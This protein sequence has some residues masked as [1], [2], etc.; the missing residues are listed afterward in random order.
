MENLVKRV[1]YRSYVIRDDLLGIKACFILL[2]PQVIQA[3]V[4][5]RVFLAFA[6]T[7][8]TWR[9]RQR[10]RTSAPTSKLKDPTI[11]PNVAIS[12][13]AAKRKINKVFLHFNLMGDPLLSNIKTILKLF[14]AD[15]LHCKMHTLRGI[16]L[17]TLKQSPE[18]LKMGTQ[19]HRSI[20]QDKRYLKSSRLPPHYHPIK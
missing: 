6:P 2:H 12:R 9:Q 4:E 3:F 15:I 14:T 19:F 13:D 5:L 11:S 10:L 7:I 8:A 17:H 16:S 18:N 1:S 20:N